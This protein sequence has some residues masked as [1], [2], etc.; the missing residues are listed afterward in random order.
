MKWNKIESEAQWQQILEDSKNTLQL[1]YKHSTRCSISSVVKGRLERA[2]APADIDFHY[3][4]LINF[5]SVSNR[6]AEDTG[7]RHES[8]Q[9]LLI[10]DGKCIYHESHT[11][12]NMD[13]II[14]EGLRA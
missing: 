1:I 4:D 11:A 7:I 3:L 8:P 12:I 2:G 6:I 5:R 13:D 9:I 14:S 10:K